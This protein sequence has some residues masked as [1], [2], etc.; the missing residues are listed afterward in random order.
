MNKLKRLSAEI[1]ESFRIAFDSLKANKLR[2][3]LATLGVVIGISFVVL[4][5]WAISGL[6]KALLETINSIGEDMLYVDKWDWAGGKSWKEVRNRKEITLQQAQELIDRVK[7]AAVSVPIISTWSAKVKFE[8][9]YYS[10]MSII[11]TSAEYGILPAGDIS[12]G[13]FFTKF[14]EI[15]TENV[16]V[17]GYKVARTLFGDSD[18]IGR[19]I[20]IKGE[21]FLVIG[22]V[23]KQGTML[24]DFIDDRIFI[25]LKKFMDLFGGE[26]RRSVTV[27]FKAGSID[28]MDE[29]REEI[30]GNMRIIRNLKPWQEDDF[31]IN[32]TKAFEEIVAKFRLYVWGIGIGMT[33]LSFIVGIIGIMNIMYVSV[34]E[35]TKEIGI[36]K[37]VG[38]KRSS[39]LLQFL[40]ESAML[41]LAGAI[42]SIAG[43]SALVFALAKFLPK[44][45]ESTAFLQPV[46]P[47]D[48]IFL[49]TLVAVFVGILAGLLPASKAAR[50]DPIES[51]RY[52]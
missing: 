20:K 43:C 13:R 29:V 41:C 8:N 21:K 15:N 39:I 31:S 9:D 37:S 40:I 47:I 11:G 33:I 50:V 28:K 18:P 3:F 34:A 2:S 48:F 46:L 36:R 22:V 10:G 26:R 30:R 44:V 16:A 51:L 23:K 19:Y 17:L 24:M 4:M 7:L 5:G 49:A 14:E 52:E 12:K 32:E 25:P 1:S 6:D 27:A 45:W 38:A 35:R 42:A